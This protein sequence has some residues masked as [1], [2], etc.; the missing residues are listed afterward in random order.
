LADGELRLIVEALSPDGRHRFRREGAAELSQSAD[1]HAA[2]RALGVSLG[3]AVKA[4]GGDLIVA[5]E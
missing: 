3:E 4:E 2:A 5:P 1:P